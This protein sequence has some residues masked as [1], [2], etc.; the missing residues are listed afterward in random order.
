MNMLMPRIPWLRNRTVIVSITLLALL[1]TFFYFSKASAKKRGPINP[2]FANYIS[3]HTAGTISRESGIRIQFTR[4]FADSNLIGTEVKGFNFTPAIKGVAKWIDAATI[5]FKA[6][7]Y[8]PSGTEYEA[9]FSL[10]LLMPVP[11]DLEDFVFDFNVINQSFEVAEPNFTAMDASKYVYQRVSGFLLT[12]DVEEAA[13]VEKLMSATHDGLQVRMKWEHSSDKKS[14]RYILDSMVRKN[15]AGTIVVS[16]NG[17]PLNLS[18]KGSHSLIIPALGDFS[19]INAKMENDG[20]PYVSL[21]FSDPL[22]LGQDLEGLIHFDRSLKD[23]K[24]KQNIDV[25]FVINGHEIKCYPGSSLSGTYK[26]YIEPGIKNRAGTKLKRAQIYALNFTDQLPSVKMLGKGVIVPA[27]NKT[28]MPFEA[29]G[30]KAVDVSITRIYEKNVAQF[31]QVNDLKGENEIYRVGRKIV[32]KMIRLDLDG[33]TDLRKRN[34]FQLNLDELVKTE[35]GAIYQVKISF[36]RAYAIYRCDASV[37]LPEN[38][39]MQPIQEEVG[40]DDYQPKEFSYWDYSE[41]YY[42]EGYQWEDRNNPC[43]DSYYNSDKWVSRNIMASDLGMIA[44]RGSGN[45]VLIAITHLITTKPI[46]GVVVDLLDFQ[47]KTIATGTTDANGMVQLNSTRKA[48][49]AIAKYKD[50]R[51]YLKLDDGS[52]LPLSQF[53]VWGDV[54]QRG[55][56]GMLYGERGVWRPGDSLYLTFILE[57]KNKTLPAFHPVVFELY[58]PLGA[59][60]KRI[61]TSTSVNGFY[62]FR[63]CTDVDDITGNYIA[64]VKVGGVTFQNKIKIETVMPN[65]LKIELNFPKE[66]IV[67]NEQTQVTLRSKWLHGAIANGLQA[68]VEATLSDIPTTFKKYPEYN[69]D[70]PTRKINPETQVVFEGKLN[71]A[72]EATFPVQLKMES[73]PAGMMQ[74]NFVTKVFEPGGSFSKDRYAVPYHPYNAYIGIK[75]PK[76][77]YRGMLLT[78]TTHWVQMV[79]VNTDGNLLSG[80]RKATARLYKLEWRWWWDKNENDLGNYAGNESYNVLYEKEVVLFN[81]VGRVSM[82]IN[83]PD[84]GRYLLLITDEDG[85]TTGK[86]FYMDWPGWAGRGD[87]DNS[88]EAAMLT[89][90]MNKSTYKVGEQATVTIP[91]PQAGRAL[92]SIESGSE[93]LETHWIEAQK[94]STTYSFTIKKNMLPNAYAHVTLVQPHGQIAN[95]RPIRMYGMMHFKVEDP[96]TKLAPVLT[97]ANVIKPDMNQSI[98]VSEANGK[99]MTYTLAIVDEGLLDLTRFKTPDPHTHFYAREALGVKT[100]DL[101]D[102]VM[103]AFGAEFNRILTIGGD[104]GI[105]RKSGDQKAKRFKPTVKFIGP[106]H[107]EAGKQGNHT[108]QIKDY[109]GSVRVMVVAGYDG[110]YGFAEKAVPVKKPLM[111]LATLPRVLRPT[112][113]VNLPVNIFALDNSI[114]SVQVKVIGNE[115]IDIIGTDKKTIQFT[116]AGDEFIHFKLKVKQGLGIARV[117]VVASSGAEESVYEV[118]LN[119]ENPNPYENNVY[120]AN[121]E[122]GKEWNLSYELPGISGTNTATLEVSTLPPINL[123]KRLKYLMMYPYGC[124]EQTTSSVF[125]QL[126]LDK[127]IELDESRKREIEKNIKAGISRLNSFQNA[128]GGL[129]YWQGEQSSDDWGTTYAGHFMIEAQNA[130]Y[131][132]PGNFLANWKKFQQQKAANWTPNAKHFGESAQA[133]RLYTLALAK[134]PDMGAMNR[135]KEV[136]NLTAASTWRLA[137]AYALAGNKNTAMQIIEKEKVS[138]PSQHTFEMEFTYGS[139]ERDEALI[140]ETL[141]LLDMKEKSTPMLIKVCENLSSNAWLSTQSTAM[142]L[143]AVAKIT[144]RYN[145]GK[146]LEFEYSLNGKTTSFKSAGQMAQLTL[147]VKGE[148]GGKLLLKNKSKQL[149]FAR[150]ISRGQPAIGKQTAMESGIKLDIVY[151]DMQDREINPAQIEQGTDFKVEV[152]I[153]N[154]GLMGNLN[155]L[156]LSQILPSGWEIH[157]NRMDN[158]PLSNK[159]Q[160]PRYQDIRDDRVYTHFDLASKQKVTYVLLLNASYV[161]RYYLPGFSCEAMYYGKAQTRVAGTWVEVVPKK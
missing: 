105:N 101:Y 108:L 10:G 144:G 48:F 99:A 9:H 109:I 96:N 38:K 106:F 39:E 112:E 24:T 131:T 148:E 159:Y 143:L 49:L 158:N 17:D 128:D 33:M 116:Q 35:P 28:L 76:G 37:D 110:A 126:A 78:D 19:P 138:V 25:K 147:P 66:S 56:K 118:E 122:P 41:E 160:T 68:K 90:N 50:Q 5:E 18:L 7:N 130:G 16:W 119:V 58:N 97:M 22:L 94:G 59:L 104:E 92:L 53:D 4:N 73:Q 45:K 124:V 103:G 13:N 134:A 71:E 57:D 149:I 32:Q 125:P 29:V 44:K 70:N 74:A 113:E 155:Y 80:S 69:F 20:S 132:L 67:K 91:T 6:E 1:S 51:G 145:E 84:W 98:Q 137:A 154:P 142:S 152:S 85:H 75:V 140:L 8:L 150:L 135:L 81:G 102:Y 157:N 46:A 77:D 27:S 136:P 82:R 107:L 146:S 133:Y 30:L 40:E 123:E 141:A 121:L 115:L 23:E 64:K 156:A 65:R 54:V 79:C 31:M 52:S 61:V 2:E 129:G 120:D 100:W 60:S 117:K 86:T 153:L 3:A 43:K 11:K 62:D 12:A 95:D 161:G 87:R 151:K 139:P 89:F 36:K 83:Y 21:Y 127:L 93:V 26:L 15:S 42:N 34:T 111:V 55:L 114:K 14:H 47:Q 72:G 63:T 88:M